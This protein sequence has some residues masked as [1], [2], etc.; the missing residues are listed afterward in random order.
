MQ[1]TTL[2]CE[3]CATPVYAR[4]LTTITFSDDSIQVCKPCRNGY[5]RLADKLK[6]QRS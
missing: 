6:G 5:R 4:D 2:L 3:A 1:G